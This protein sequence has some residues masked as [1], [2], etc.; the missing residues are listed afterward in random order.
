MELSKRVAACLAV[1]LAVAMTAAIV[2]A[3]A[4]VA[5][6]WSVFDWRDLFATPMARLM[7]ID[8]SVT[9]AWVFV[10]MESDARKRG[11]TALAWLPL[12]IVFPSAALLAYVF[13]RRDAAPGA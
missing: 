10:W 3:T 8:F 7:F 4:G 6:P 11:R 2:H 5:R 12:L 13:A 9:V 1:A